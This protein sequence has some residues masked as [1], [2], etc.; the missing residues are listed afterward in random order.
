[1]K[2]ILEF[3]LTVICLTGCINEK[4]EGVD[5]ITGDAVPEFSVVMNDGTVVSDISMKGKISCIVFFHTS[6][7]DC[8]KTLPVVQ[9]IYNEYAP[10]D[11]IFTL[12]SREQ[13]ADEIDI[14]W[15]EKSLNMPY[16]AQSDRKVYNLFAQTRI[17][18]IYMIDKDGIIRYI[19]TDDPIPS[20][21]DLMSSIESLIR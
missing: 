3:I 19:F 1:M 11:I 8:Q 5:L 16:S 18:R 17:P 4:I 14:F 20:Y 9:E 6:C 15:K 7:P 10:K 12:I 21:D 13:T 2:K